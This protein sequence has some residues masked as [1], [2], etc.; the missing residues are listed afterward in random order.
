LFN[1]NGKISLAVLDTSG[2]FSAWNIGPTEGTYYW[3][4]QHGNN[5]NTSFIA[6]ASSSTLVKW[7]FS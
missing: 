3:S 2:N 6:G 5:Q 1:D 7:I 4:E